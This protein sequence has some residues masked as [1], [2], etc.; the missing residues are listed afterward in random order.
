MRDRKAAPIN[1]EGRIY[2]YALL[3]IEDGF[4][5]SYS[6]CSTKF[7]DAAPLWFK[8]MEKM[9]RSELARYSEVAAEIEATLLDQS[10]VIPIDERRRRLQLFRKA[11]TFFVDMAVQRF[12]A[13]KDETEQKA[14]CDKDLSQESNSSKDQETGVSPETELLFK[15]LAK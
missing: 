4:K 1:E 12:N 3:F 8:A 6:L 14:Q 11:K 13:A 9:P 15:S 5:K 7:P 2:G 10:S